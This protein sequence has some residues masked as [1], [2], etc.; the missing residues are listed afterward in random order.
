MNQCDISTLNYLLGKIEGIAWGIEQ[1]NARN[2][3]LD[4][5]EVL[6]GIVQKT[7]VDS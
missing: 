1:E 2:A 5:C 4:V 6:A 7:E 3:L